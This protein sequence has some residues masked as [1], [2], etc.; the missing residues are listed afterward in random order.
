MTSSPRR[1]L[2]IVINGAPGAGKTTLLRKLTKDL[3]LPG[4]GK[5]DIKELLFDHLGIGD[6]NWSRDVG[7]ATFEMVYS[8]IEKWIGLGHDLIIENAFYKE[9]AAAR[10]A[11]IVAD[12]NA[13]FVEIYCATDPEVRMKRF[14]QRTKD[15]VRH[16]G[17]ADTVIAEPEDVIQARYAPLEIG[18]LIRVDTTVFGDKE[19]QG[20]LEDVSS[21][22]KR[23]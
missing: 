4:I 23:D 20:L 13:V 3:S 17:H 5:D 6:H 22:L 12:N 16:A 9:F 2:L 19:Y 7:V 15:G 11:K 1:P 10:I 21:F 18:N 8:L 14:I